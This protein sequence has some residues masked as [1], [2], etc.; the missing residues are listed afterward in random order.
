MKHTPEPEV[1]DETI[2]YYAERE[3][4]RLA[5]Q[6]RKDSLQA[7]AEI[8]QLMVIRD[9]YG[10]ELDLF[11]GDSVGINS[12]LKNEDYLANKNEKADISL[13]TSLRGNGMFYN[14]LNHGY[15][16]SRNDFPGMLGMYMSMYAGKDWSSHLFFNKTNIS[17][18]SNIEFETET[19]KLLEG[20]YNSSIPKSYL[21]YISNEKVLGIASASLN[22][23][24]FWETFPSVYAEAMMFGSYR[25]PSEK[26]REGVKVLVDF[27]SIM[28]D[29][30]AL[31]KLAN[32]NSVFVLKDLVP[33]EVE[34]FTYEYNEDYSES[35]KVKK[36][37]TEIFPDFLLMF[38]SENKE[39]MTKLLE[40]AC[41]NNVIYK[42]GNYYYSDGKSRDFPFAM[43]FT[44]TS[45]NGFCIN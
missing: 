13:W 39:F 19:G 7:A 12:I 44:V 22:A 36:T 11:F 26:E 40:L 6:K 15:Y 38:G 16:G 28:M 34:Y 37:K 25:G 4:E 2:E 20:I 27:L 45:D 9:Y 21:K 31:G 10:K 14:T 30:E 5:R 43:Y 23:T 1:R 41:K 17:I 18:K 35:K 3:A 33:T 29:E 42:K 8:K 32:G 24:K